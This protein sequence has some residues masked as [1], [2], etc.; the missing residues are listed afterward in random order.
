[1]ENEKTGLQREVEKYVQL[2]EIKTQLIG[3]F[4]LVTLVGL[5]YFFGIGEGRSQAAAEL[6]GL[7]RV[8]L[9]LEKIERAMQQNRECANTVLNAERGQ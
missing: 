2:Q 6:P 3:L 1:M 5:S 7:S 9:R 4:V 8:D